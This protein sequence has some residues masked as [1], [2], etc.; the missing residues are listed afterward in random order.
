[1]SVYNKKLIISEQERKEILSQY[2]LI[3]LLQEADVKAGESVTTK[4]T[5]TGGKYLEASGNF[6]DLTDNI[7]AIKDFCNK[8]PN[9]KIVEVVVEAGESQIPNTDNE[10]GGARVDVG[11]LSDKRSETI[12]AWLQKKFTEIKSTDKNFKTP[13]KFVYSKSGGTTPWV[14]QLFCP[15]DKLP[16]GD[17]QGYACLNKDFD[18][19]NGKPNWVKGKDTTYAAIRQKY[20]TEQFVKVTFRL[21][22]PSNDLVKMPP[23]LECLSGMIIEYNYDSTVELSNNGTASN[24]HCCTRGL[25]KLTV[26]GLPLKRTDNYEYANINNHPQYLDI[27]KIQKDT[28][29]QGQAGVAEYYIAKDG[30]TQYLCVN[31]KDNGKKQYIQNSVAEYIL[32]PQK[33]PMNNYRYN[34]FKITPE[35]AQNIVNNSRGNSGFLTINVSEATPNQHTQAARIIVKDPKGNIYYDSCT[36]G[37]CGG[38]NTGDFKVSY[39]NTGFTS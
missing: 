28:R 29:P 16:A 18:P 12:K 36:G 13:Q 14:G 38:R 31:I 17:T 21:A 26:N 9:G 25:F 2:N 6:K 30:S 22:A 37:D 34:T 23:K 7:T 19:G 15:K 11:Y 32:N 10:T 27:Q 35:M 4:I 5:F 3:N 20:L 24:V 1:M 39:C 33:G 8:V